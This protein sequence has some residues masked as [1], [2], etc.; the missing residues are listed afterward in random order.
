MA[1]RV[2]DIRRFVKIELTSTVEPKTNIFCSVYHFSE[3]DLYI[4]DVYY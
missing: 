2:G 4:N 1:I 3:D